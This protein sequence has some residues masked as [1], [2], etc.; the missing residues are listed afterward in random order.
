MP[1]KMKNAKEE[2]CDC[3]NCGGGKCCCGY[4]GMHG[5]G[6]GKLLFGIILLLIGGSWLGND[7]GWWNFSLPWFPLAITLLAIGLIVKWFW[8]R[9]Y[10]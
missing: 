2:E 6:F 5:K 3:G 9:Q 1:R 8:K 4:G 7:L 10:C